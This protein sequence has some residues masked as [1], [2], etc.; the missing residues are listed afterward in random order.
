M[1]QQDNLKTKSWQPTVSTRANNRTEEITEDAPFYTLIRQNGATPDFLNIC[2]K[3]GNETALPIPSIKRIWFNREPHA[4][5]IRFD[6]TSLITITGR[7]L[8]ELH[9]HLLRVKISEIREYP[10][11]IEKRFNEDEL[12]ISRIEIEDEEDSKK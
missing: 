8:R 3:D 11:D 5:V 6:Y 1:T 7:N 4:I 9:K 2:P 10:A 12:Y